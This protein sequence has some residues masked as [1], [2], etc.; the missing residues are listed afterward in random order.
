MGKWRAIKDFSEGEQHNWICVQ[1]QKSSKNA[2]NELER[3]AEGENGSK[4]PGTHLWV[5]TSMT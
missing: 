5:P 1:N 4:K 2:E 3:E